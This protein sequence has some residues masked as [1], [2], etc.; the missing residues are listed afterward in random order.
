MRV[1]LQNFRPRKEKGQAGV[2]FMV[3]MLVI[4]FFLFLLLSLSILFVISD[5]VEFATFMA[6]RTYKAGAS[7]E[8]MQFQH[9]QEVF[10][11]YTDKIQ[12][13][14]TNFT[15]ER[16]QISPDDN[17]TA[18][19]LSTYDISLFY[20][21]PLFMLGGMPNPRVKLATDTFLG[22][23]PSY[24]ECQSFFQSL[25]K[26]LGIDSSYFWEQMEDNGC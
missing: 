5:Y 26:K 23:D 24:E 4:F 12:G 9:A 7:R 19:L 25:G 21:P 22:R 14:A 3:I 11:S 17:Q 18:G 15:L 6:A 13:I 16:A 2:E 1:S 20:F 8:E 10:Q